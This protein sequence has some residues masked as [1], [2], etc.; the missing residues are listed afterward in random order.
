MPKQALGG[1][2]RLPGGS[3]VRVAQGMVREVGEADDIYPYGG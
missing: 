2:M 1:V 3:G